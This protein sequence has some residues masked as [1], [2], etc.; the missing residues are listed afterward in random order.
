MSINNIQQTFFLQ[1]Q[2]I[3]MNNLILLNNKGGWFLI[4]C[5][6][7][8]SVYLQFALSRHS[9]THLVARRRAT[10]R[11]FHCLLSCLW[12]KYRLWYYITHHPCNPLRWLSAVLRAVIVMTYCHHSKVL[13]GLLSLFSSWVE[14]RDK[15]ENLLTGYPSCLPCFILHGHSIYHCN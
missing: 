15:N 12:N 7:V 9:L 10:T 2:K 11:S 13:D 8:L 1:H 6:I 3:P 5:L 14:P 4:N